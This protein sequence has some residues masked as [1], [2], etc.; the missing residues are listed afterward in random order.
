MLLA[1]SE[2]YHNKHVQNLQN[3]P[4]MASML[5]IVQDL[6]DKYEQKKQ[7]PQE[8][9]SNVDQEPEAEAPPVHGTD[10]DEKN[11]ASPNVLPTMDAHDQEDDEE[12][13]DYIVTS[14]LS[15]RRRPSRFYRDQMNILMTKYAEWWKSEHDM[16][17]SFLPRNN[18][19]VILHWM[20][21]E[22]Q[23]WCPKRLDP[24]QQHIF[25]QS[26]KGVLHKYQLDPCE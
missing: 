10:N 20:R 5:P 15:L 22:E 23:R 19:K 8:N 9:R 26:I 16:I 13:E 17:Q 24:Q 7:E 18:A 3:T 6:Y 2:H 12:E 21:L 1:Q 25:D 14:F 4:S 11:T